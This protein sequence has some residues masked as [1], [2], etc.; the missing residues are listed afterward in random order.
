MSRKAV[1]SF[2][3]SALSDIENILVWYSERQAA[4]V[5]QRLVIEIIGRIETL[6]DHPEL[7][8]MVPEFD[9]PAPRE[10]I[11][12]PFRIVYRHDGGRIR[13]VRVWRS[14]RILKL[15]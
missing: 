5:G 2:A 6:S 9:I 3:P 15:D 1:I 12:S 11:H 8:R 14:E 7:G 4:D 13:I 10:L